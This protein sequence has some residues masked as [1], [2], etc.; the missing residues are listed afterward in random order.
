MKSIVIYSSTKYGNTEKIAAAMAKELQADLH[1][2][3]YG[4]KPDPILDDYSL[5]GLG[6]GVKLLQYERNLREYVPRNR[7]DGRYVF[8][9]MTCGSGWDWIHNNRVKDT[10]LHQGAHLL[11]QFTC[12]GYAGTFPLSII[13][14]LNRGHPDYLDIKHAG[15]FA[16]Q[17]RHLAAMHVTNHH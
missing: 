16:A 3:D 11:G 10:L 5:I 1:C 2:L 15:V 17:M 6:S 12:L 4:N 14:G 9:F 8:L 13:G 7:F